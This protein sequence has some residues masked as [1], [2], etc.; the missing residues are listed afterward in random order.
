MKHA[1]AAGALPGSQ[2]DPF[3]RMLIAQGQIE[4]LPIVTSDH[5]FKQYP[6]KIIW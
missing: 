4:E 2:R 1:L 3:D 6:V 5:A